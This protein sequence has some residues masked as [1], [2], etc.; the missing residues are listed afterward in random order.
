M[1]MNWRP[2]PCRSSRS[3]RLWPLLVTQTLGAVNDNMFKTAMSVLLLAEL[4]AQGP[5]LVALAGGVFIVPY[6]L[7]SA[8]AGQIADRFDKARIIRLVKLAE[9]PLMLLA[10]ASLLLHSPSLQ[11]A[12]LFGLGVQATF[13]S[14]L[15]YGILPDHLKESELVAGNGLVEAG[16]FAGILAG[17]IAG[18]ALTGLSQ[19]PEIVAGLGVAPGLLRRGERVPHPAGA[20]RRARLAHRLERASARRRRCCAPRGPTARSGCACWG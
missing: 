7:L 5:A 11:F 15:K 8:T 10:G 3:P 19:G 4:T 14:P 16:T 17:I 9:M 13:F 6:V 18:G 1:F 12:A 2:Q 20:V